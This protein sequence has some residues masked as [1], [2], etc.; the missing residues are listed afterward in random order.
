M[1]S[2]GWRG[3]T[4][5]DLWFVRQTPPVPYP[6]QGGPPPPRHLVRL[7]PLWAVAL[8]AGVLAVVSGELPVAAGRETLTRAA[9][10]LLFLMAVTVLAELSDAAGVFDVIAR[11]AAVVARGRK[12][13]LFLLVIAVATATT[14]LLSLDTTAVLLTPV[15]LS[16]CAQLDVP[17]LPFAIATVWLSNT[18]SLLLPVSNLTNLLAVQQLRLSPIQFAGRM[19]APE[20]AAV[21]VTTAAL[22]VLHRRQF[23]GR[24]VAPPAPQV[25]D[26]VLFVVCAA[27]VVAF[28]V[29]VLGAVN[30][31][32]AALACAGVAVTAFAVRRR[33]ELRWSLVPWRLV[34]TA[35]G[36]FVVVEGAERHG[37][38]GWLAALAGGGTGYPGLLRLAA[39]A[40]TCGNVVNNLPAYL[41]FE[42]V[43]AGSPDRLLAILIGVNAGPVIS[44]WGSLATLLWLE[45]C[46]ARGVD[47]S[48]RSFALTGLLLAPLVIVAATAAL[49]L[50]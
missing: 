38:G 33:S 40:A 44:I 14:V 15:V 26:S 19:W 42:P 39:S 7:P 41:A 17:P 43:S 45:R 24:Y 28:G 22:F 9:P 49:L 4:R 34:L 48:V 31:T 12:T 10:V 29:A 5:R 37:L 32:V 13:V 16:V 25:A 11:R 20:L 35:S 21:A 23:R 6:R 30:V 2:F 8:T 18:A 36:L 27:S 47:V 50:T 3:V 46:R 1:R